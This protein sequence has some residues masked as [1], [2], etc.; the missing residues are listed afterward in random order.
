MPALVC[1]KKGML[2]FPQ[3]ILVVGMQRV[4]PVGGVLL[5]HYKGC[6]EE[7]MEHS[8]CQIL[9]DFTE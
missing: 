1:C 9:W 8:E 4:L 3:F 2:G 5:Q 7:R 6:P